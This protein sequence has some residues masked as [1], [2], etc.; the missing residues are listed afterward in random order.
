[1]IIVQCMA[2]APFW[3]ASQ[4]ELRNLNSNSYQ[5]GLSFLYFFPPDDDDEVSLLDDSIM[6]QEKRAEL[7]A[8]RAE[9]IRLQKR[10]AKVTG[11]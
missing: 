7:E 6:L 1:M 5:V 9:K 3:I 4:T 8:L 11:L 2:G 10:I